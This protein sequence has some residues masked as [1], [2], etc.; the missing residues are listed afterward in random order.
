MTPSQ[1]KKITWPDACQR[2]L[3]VWNTHL[4]KGKMF[5]LWIFS[6]CIQKWSHRTVRVG[7]WFGAV[8]A[9]LH[10][11]TTCFV[12]LVA[13]VVSCRVATTLDRFL[14]RLPLLSPVNPK[15]WIATLRDRNVR[16]SV[17]SRWQNWP[18]ALMKFVAK[19]K[20]NQI[21]KKKLLIEFQLVFCFPKKICSPVV[22]WL[23]RF[24]PIG[25]K[26][27]VVLNSIL[28]SFCSSQ[29]VCAGVILNCSRRSVNCGLNWPET[30]R[31][32]CNWVPLLRQLSSPKVVFFRGQTSRKS[33]LNES[34]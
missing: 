21:T 27:F 3:H 23:E 24:N 28:F 1:C 34:N 26:L 31:I 8:A 5:Y 6:E 12:R 18:P 33:R 22:C 13:A 7:A 19:E 32:N 2:A 15:C 20:S 4:M 10:A 29:H 25:R 30:L 9:L 17:A 14:E 16:I 11:G